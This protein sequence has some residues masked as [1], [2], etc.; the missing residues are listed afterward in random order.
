MEEHQVYY[1]GRRCADEARS[2]FGQEWPLD[3]TRVAD[4]TNHDNKSLNKRFIQ[5]R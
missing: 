3:Q 5:V 4:F 1:L 2:Y